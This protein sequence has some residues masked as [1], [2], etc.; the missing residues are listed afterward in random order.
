MH[1]VSTENQQKSRA[2]DLDA[3]M[4][5]QEL[6]SGKQLIDP[7]QFSHSGSLQVQQV[8]FSRK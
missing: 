2:A 3:S 7:A 1:P 6:V 4:D 8:G 5:Q